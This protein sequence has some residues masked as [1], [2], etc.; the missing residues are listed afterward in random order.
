MSFFTVF[1]SVI[2]LEDKVR[3]EKEDCPECWSCSSIFPAIHTYFLSVLTC[4]I[5]RRNVCV[6]W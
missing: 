1:I 3:V 6:K 5:N 4:E 2:E